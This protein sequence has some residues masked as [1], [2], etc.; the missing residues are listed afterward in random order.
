MIRANESVLLYLKQGVDSSNLYF[1]QNVLK[2]EINKI[3]TYEGDCT[4]S[5][6]L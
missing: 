3:I 1:S 6:W 4:Y 2:L 5:L